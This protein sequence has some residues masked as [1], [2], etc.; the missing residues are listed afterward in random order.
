MKEK[1]DEIDVLISPVKEFNKERFFQALNLIISE[2]DLESLTKK[3]FELK[4]Y[5]EGRGEKENQ[6]SCDICEG[7]NREAGRGEVDRIAD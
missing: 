6:K 1:N 2:D 3:S 5:E 7:F 4:F